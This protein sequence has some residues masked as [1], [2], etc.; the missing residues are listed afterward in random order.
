MVTVLNFDGSYENQSFYRHTAYQ[1]ID[2]SNVKNVNGYCAPESLAEIRK[3]LQERSS[4]GIT[5]IGS[6]N[7]HY[8]TYLLLSEI[9]VPFTLVLF[10][11]HTDAMPGLYGCSLLSCGSW[12]LHALENLPLMQR[13]VM[14]GVNREWAAVM[15]RFYAARVTFFTEDQINSENEFKNQL[16]TAIPTG[17]VYISIDKDVLSSAEAMT[18]WEQGTMT[19]QEMLDIA[20]EI[21]SRRMIRGFDVCGEYAVTAATEF[22]PECRHATARN[23]RANRIILD[24]ALNMKPVR[25]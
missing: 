22:L 3:K 9:S 15:P 6:G 13:V 10:D 18:N 19:L 17:A 24:M 11:Y 21:G 5:F 7:Y 4:N 23:N 8:V 25:N 12:V 14:L 20:I 16:L 1:W 2:C